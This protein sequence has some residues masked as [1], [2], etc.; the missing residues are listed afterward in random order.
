MLFSEAAEA[1]QE[2]DVLSH[3]LSGSSGTCSRGPCFDA[4]EKRTRMGPILVPFS[5]T[6]EAMQK[7]NGHAW[8]DS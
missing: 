1:A 6:P 8:H 2:C 7:Q 5:D 3:S 4:S